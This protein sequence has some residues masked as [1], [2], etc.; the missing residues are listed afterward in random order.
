MITFARIWLSALLRRQS[1]RLIGTTLGIAL[2]VGLLAAIAGF[3]ASTES[4]MTRQAIADVPIDWQVQLAPGSDPNAAAQELQSSPG[5]ANVVQVGYFDTPGFQASTGNT[6]QTTGPGKVLGLGPGYRETF[7]AEVR[8]LVGSGSVLLAQQTAANLHAAPGSVV[9]IQRGAGL[10]PVQVTVDGIVDLPMADPLFQTIG[11]SAGSAPQAPPDNVL[12]LPLDQWHA[13]FDPVAAISPSSAVIQLHASIPHH[14]PSSPTNAFTQVTGE[15]RNYETRMTGQAVVGNNLATRLDVAR[16]EFLYARVLFLFLGLPG[17]ILAAVLTT[18]V[19]ASGAVRRRRDMALLRMRGASTRHILVAATLESL[20]VGVIGII[21][22]FTIAAVALRLSLGRWSLGNGTRST[23]IWSAVVAA[24]GLVIA[25]LTVLYPAWR[26]S[27]GQTVAMSRRAILREHG[28]WWE[29]IGLDFI[30]LALAG[31]VYWRAA[32]NGYQ[33][34]VVPEGIPTVS[35]SYTSFFAPLLLWLGASL[36]ALRLTRLVLARNGRMI[37]FITNPLSGRLSSLV[38]ASISRQRGRI[39]V[40]LTILALAI[41]FASSTAIFNAT[42]QTQA[43]VDA[44][45]SN[46]A[47]VTITGVQGY[48]GA[49]VIPQIATLPGVAAV[50]PM[51]HRFAYVGNDLQDLYGVDPA[52]LG[53]ATRIVDAFFVGGS[54]HEVMT[55]LANTPDGV[56]VSPETVLDYQLQ[57]G[58]TIK[59]RLKSAADGQYHAIPF[60][61][62]GVA[63]EFPT[64]PSDSFLVANSTYIA[65]QTGS[66]AAE[67]VLIRTN[68][69]PAGVANQVRTTLGPASGA[70]VRDIAAQQRMINSSLTAVS[71]H[72]LTRI[73]LAFA[74]ILAA[75]GSGLVLALGLDDRRRTLAIAASLGAKSRQLGSFVWSEAGVILLGG[76]V[77]GYLLGWGVAHMLIKLL[78]HV[79]DPPPQHATIPWVYLAVLTVVTIAAIAIAGRSITRTSQREILQTIRRL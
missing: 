29:R 30:L 62:V 68:G 22:G 24:I 73:E 17:V 48:D 45:L 34:V 57:L 12:L 19:V 79:F 67:T 78:T 1:A 47:D 35:V 59:L 65:Q 25:A 2:T 77:G 70:T 52:S 61:Y 63:R 26:D 15:A 38:G 27:R 66:G 44:E 18:V 13:L 32:R 46:G 64:A 51:Q 5:A 6:V 60:H 74:I 43:N 41:A 40:G 7:P 69:D 39:A 14:L 37:S 55:R 71:L 53:S 54:A 75:A 72:G 76:L 23:L 42:Y 28:R 58:D 50:Q 33:I 31:I 21:L 8:D 4:T 36:L 9:T 3:F 49:A 10:D 11:A 20:C 56:L 16:E